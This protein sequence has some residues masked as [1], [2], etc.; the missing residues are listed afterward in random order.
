M[1]T[2]VETQL[3]LAGNDCLRLESLDVLRRRRWARRK[4]EPGKC[5]DTY[6]YQLHGFLYYTNNTLKRVCDC[7]RTYRWGFTEARFWSVPK[8]R[9][10]RWNRRYEDHEMIVSLARP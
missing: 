9:P 6:A 1:H 8:K 4:P 7:L 10:V 3:S 5:E 2:G